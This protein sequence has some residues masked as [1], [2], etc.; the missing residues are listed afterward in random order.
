MEYYL[1]YKDEWEQSTLLD[2]IKSLVQNSKMVTEHEGT[3]T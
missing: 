3:H 1:V 2:S